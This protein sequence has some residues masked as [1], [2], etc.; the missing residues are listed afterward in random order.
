M[1]QELEIQRE[2][3]ALKKAQHCLGCF[4]AAA[5]SSYGSYLIIFKS[6]HEAILHLQFLRAGE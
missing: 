3:E 2:V 1:V 6:S 4:A 5:L